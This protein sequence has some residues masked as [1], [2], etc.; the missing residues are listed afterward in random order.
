MK[1][2]LD[3]LIERLRKI[4]KTKIVSIDEEIKALRKLREKI[5]R[6]KYGN[7]SQLFGF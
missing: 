4:S 7:Q 1:P 6:E 3:K 5:W 2:I